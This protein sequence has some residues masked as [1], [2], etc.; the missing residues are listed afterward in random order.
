[1]PTF[2]HFT[3]TFGPITL[4]KSTALAKG[5]D[6]YVFQ[7]PHDPA[8]LIKV[9]NTEAYNAYLNR[10][11]LKRIYKKFQREGAYRVY[12]NEFSE[13]ASTCTTSSNVWNVPMSRVIGLVQ[14]SLGLGQLVEKIST[15]DGSLAPTLANIM[16]REGITSVISDQLDAFFEQLIAAHVVISDLSAKNIAI[17]RN[18]EGVFGMYLIDGFGVLPLIPLYAWSKRLND[19]RMRHK[20][21]KWRARIQQQYS[22]AHPS[23]EHVVAR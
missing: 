15:D 8:L 13:Y 2:A 23:H 21:A 9:V 3:R 5:A 19:R 10:K 18:A 16:E 17:G 1:M 22:H 6:R 20:Y 14:T 11:P 4:N 7:H 12:L